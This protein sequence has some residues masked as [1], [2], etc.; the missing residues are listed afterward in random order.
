MAVLV[1][2]G[3]EAVRGELHAALAG[4]GRS[5]LAGFARVLDGHVERVRQQLLHALGEAGRGAVGLHAHAQVV[6]LG[7]LAGEAFEL[8]QGGR[9]RPQAAARGDRHELELRRLLRLRVED[10]D[11]LVLLLLAEVELDERAGV[12]RL[13]GGEYLLR[14]V[15]VAE[16]DV[17]DARRELL[18]VDAVDLAEVQL[19]LPRP[20]A[21]AVHEQVR[22]DD[23]DG[24]GRQALHEC[25]QDL[26]D[27]ARVGLVPLVLGVHHQARV[28]DL[29]LGDEGEDGDLGFFLAVLRAEA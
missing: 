4:V 12:E 23:V 26:L 13:R 29:A 21:G 20:D 8:W 24:G 25:R 1:V 27:A 28:H 18:R 10:D 9:D 3:E 6:V 7:P 19:A 14:P 15:Q 16:A 22:E 5:G 17:L 11:A 2:G